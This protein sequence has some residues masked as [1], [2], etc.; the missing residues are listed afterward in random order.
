M[1]IIIP[2]IDPAN[3]QCYLERASALLSAELGVCSRSLDAAVT[4]L[5]WWGTNWQVT[6]WL[7]IFCKDIYIL[8]YCTS[9]WGNG[10]TT[11]ILG[12]SRKA[13]T[14]TS[15]PPCNKQQ[16]REGGFK[17]R[18]GKR[19]IM[20]CHWLPC[21]A[22]CSHLPPAPC[23][24]WPTRNC[25]LAWFVASSLRREMATSNIINTGGDADIFMGNGETQSLRLPSCCSDVS[26]G[27][28][29]IV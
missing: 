16:C 11:K 14:V 22:P 5:G 26:F 18:F 7:Q 23:A 27:G 20:G 28:I 10:I 25:H 2:I 8:L 4:R 13:F 3:I 21:A 1:I 9:Y 17:I 12:T 29:I 15:P 6:G 24:P 19:S